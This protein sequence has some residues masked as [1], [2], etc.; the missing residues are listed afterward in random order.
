MCRG[1]AGRG[2]AGRAEL[3]SP[4][5]LQLGRAKRAAGA[6]RSGRRPGSRVL[7][8][9]GSL[10]TLTRVCPEPVLPPK[11]GAAL[12][13]ERTPFRALTVRATRTRLTRRSRATQVRRIRVRRIDS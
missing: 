2:F 6:S 12:Q 3:G 8:Y 11:A 13:G 10:A 1:V 7:L 5:S 4:P 9:P